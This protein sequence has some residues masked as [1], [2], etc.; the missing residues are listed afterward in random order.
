[1]ILCLKNKI[2]FFSYEEGR[3]V[4][5]SLIIDGTLNGASFKVPKKEKEDYNLETISSRRR[6]LAKIGSDVVLGIFH[7]HSYV[8]VLCM[9]ERE[10]HSECK[11]KKKE[12]AEHYKRS[13]DAFEMH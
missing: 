3:D 13:C 10:K 4:N 8:L 12:H 11:K 9:L 7:S 1:M 5:R 2:L 6:C